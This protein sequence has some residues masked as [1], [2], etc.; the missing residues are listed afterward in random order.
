MFA[1]TVSA[2]GALT[3][4]GCPGTA[5]ASCAVVR[6]SF[7]PGAVILLAALLI[8]A[9][10]TTAGGQSAPASVS[11]CDYEARDRRPA[12]GRVFFPDGDLFRPLQADPKE[13]RV[14]FKY[15]RVR[16]PDEAL[17]EGSGAETITAGAISV[18][19]VVGVWARHAGMSCRG[20]QVSLFGGVFSQFNLDAPSRDLINSDF[21][22]GT[23]IS[24]RTDGLSGRI[25]LYHQSSHLGEFVPRHPIA[26][27]NF[28]YQAIDGL[29]SADRERWRAY[30]GA[31]YLF[32]MNGGGG[33]LLL[34]TGGE[35]RSRRRL[36][37]FFRP[38]AGADFTSLE[39][40][41]WG[42]TSS[43]TAGLEWTSPA[44][45][46]RMRATFTVVNGYT[47]FGQFAVQ[48]RSRSA[49][50]QIQIEF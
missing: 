18:G 45:S 49:G 3:G 14:G 38:V 36:G 32:F 44:M 6:A 4:D 39:A 27:I 34:Q 46:R 10:P 42:L 22:V 23:Q 7:T 31:G 12:R 37:G 2:A 24:A 41:S 47:P 8:L 30:A 20:V 13:P 5:P 50:L 48:E 1:V 21:V 43:V 15:L 40:R 28:G 19:G 17:G 9:V 33:S 11:H 29:V 26:D 25:R 35:V 16:I